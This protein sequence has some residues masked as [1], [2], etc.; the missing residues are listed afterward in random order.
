MIKDN[1]LPLC[2][3]IGSLP[4]HN[5]DAALAFSFTMDIPFLPQIPIRNPWEFM[6]AQALEG[7]AGLQVEN[8]GTVSL[9][10]E[11]WKTQSHILERKLNFAFKNIITPNAF[12][13][14]E[15]SNATSSSW[16]PFL[17]ELEERKIKIA[18]I[19]IAGPL[20]C[21]WA[22]RTK[23]G[24]LLDATP[25]L[26]NQV[27]KL[28][29]A[30]AIAMS[31]RLIRQN[32]QTLCYIDEPGLYV[33][34]PQNFKHVLAFQELKIIIQSLKRENISVGLHC[35]SNTSWN[36]ILLLGLDYLSIDT[37]LSLENL[38]SQKND[39]FNFIKQG[40]RMSFG[41]V[42]T[43]LENEDIY[44]LNATSLYNNISENMAKAFPEQPDFVRQ[45]LK[46]AI[47]TP[48]CGLAML[49]P[50]HAEFILTTLKELTRL[51]KN[52]S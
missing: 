9:D 43:N 40:G 34:S 23:Q 24:S 33:Y 17:W 27:F 41:A 20:T 5:I 16:Y 21:N 42:P 51:C 32:I 36:Q 6:L 29:L 45:T 1:D 4:H 11:V 3:A 25:E 44:K 35:C 31:R 38:L 13:G 18:K 2:T 22:I 37:D 50:S 28:I 7:L 52:N 19:Q 49:S 46:A 14:F 15:P 39:F 48:A 12:E 8:E 26:A 47:Y 30:R 10:L